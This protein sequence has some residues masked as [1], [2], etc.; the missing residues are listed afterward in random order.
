MLTQFLT[1]RFL[2]IKQIINKYDYENIIILG[3]EQEIQEVEILTALIVAEGIDKKKITAINDNFGS[4]FKNILYIDD[5]LKEKNIKSINFVTAPWHSHKSK[6]I[7]QKN[8]NVDLNIISNLDNPFDYTFNKKKLSY[9]NIK[10][11]IYLWFSVFF[12]YL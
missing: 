10:V 11:I 4:T 5:I 1:K 7:W 12:N 3:R 9:E 2:D 6:L 8:S